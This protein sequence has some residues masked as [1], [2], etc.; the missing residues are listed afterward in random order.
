MNNHIKRQIEILK[1][2]EEFSDRL[3]QIT[4]AN[5]ESDADFR[6]ACL[7][8]YHPSKSTRQIFN[9]AEINSRN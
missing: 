6:L 5:S 4:W 7:I 3:R 8:Q 9:H 2:Q 1:S